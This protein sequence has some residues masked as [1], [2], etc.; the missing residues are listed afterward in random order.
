M[1]GLI[2]IFGEDCVIIGADIPNV[3]VETA[4]LTQ[5]GYARALV[6]PKTT[7]EIQALALYAKEQHYYLIPRGAGT[8]V[9]GATFPVKG[10]IIID[11]SWMNQI[12][13]LDEATRTLFVEPG[14]TL[15][16]IQ[17]FVAAKGY[18][19]PP[20]PGSNKATIGGTVATNAGGMRAV[21]YGV[22]RNYVRQMVVVLPSGEKMTVG[23]LTEKNSS[24]YDLKDLFIGSEGT[25]G[26]ITEIAL[27]VVVPPKVTCSLLIGFD[28]LSDVTQSVNALLESA[29][30]PTALEFFE[31]EGIAYSERFLNLTFPLKEAK[32]Y[33]LLTI[34]GNQETDVEERLALALSLT[35]YH[36]RVSYLRLNE[37][38]EDRVWK[39]RGAIVSGVEAVTKQEPLDIVV[40][41]NK[42]TDTVQKI[43]ELGQALGLATVTFG[44]AGDGNIHVC[45]LKQELSDEKWEKQLSLLLGELYHF[46]ALQKGLPSAEH[47]IGLLKK[48]YFLK[49]IDPTLLSYLRQIKAMFDPE[50]R[51]NP[52]KML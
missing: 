10:E 7:Q 13:G 32:N 6:F 4:L 45:I 39:L 49:E 18:F 51:L 19:Y 27:R 37:E 14:V 38:V 22:T 1:Q 47:G 46:V 42:I 29:V 9:T 17:R 8:G 41:L 28:S 15:E 35:A 5:K 23:S 43:K 24:G 34:D 16:E 12:I 44:H 3:Y 48:P 40:P 26:L 21:K 33:L 30:N 52:T 20:D 25:L 36:R 50:N 2:E 31:D 11:F